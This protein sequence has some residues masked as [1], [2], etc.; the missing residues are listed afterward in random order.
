MKTYTL[1]ESDVADDQKT[2]TIAETKETTS[3]ETLTIGQ[4][5]QSHN[6]KLEQIKR[7]KVEADLI[8]DKLVEIDAD[9]GIDLTVKEIPT[10]LVQSVK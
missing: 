10:K 2:I 4:L 8:V 9:E 6:D 1:A 3:E 7:L 5:K